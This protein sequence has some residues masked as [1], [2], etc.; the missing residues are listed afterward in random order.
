[1]AENGTNILV[2]VDKTVVRVTGLSIKGLNTRQLEKLLCEKLKG[3]VRVIGVTGTSIE[4]D[5]YGVEEE[6]ILRDSD[7]LIQIVAMADGITVSDI[8]ILSQVEKIKEVDIDHIPAHS[9]YGC[10]KERWL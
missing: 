10:R 1:M 9:E 4:M 5:V 6:D 7:G 8:G 3:E 2:Q